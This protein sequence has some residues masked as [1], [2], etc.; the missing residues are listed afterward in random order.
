MDQQLFAEFTSSKAVIETDTGAVT[1]PYVRAGHGPALLLLHGFPQS[2]AMWHKVAPALAEHFTVIASDLR[3][4]GDASRPTAEGKNLYSKRAMAKDQLELMRQL[5]FQRFSILAHDR[6]ARVAHRLA[7]DHSDAVDRL[8]VLDIAP[9]LSMYEQTDV[10]FATVYWHWFFLIQR[11][12]LPETLISH[13][14]EFMLRSFMGGRHAGL[15]AFSPAAWAEYVRVAQDPAA[16]HAMCED[17]RAAATVDLEHDREDR[18]GGR[19]LKCPVSVIWGEFSGLARCLSP[20]E[21]WKE[22]A[23][24]VQGR[25]LPCGHYIAEEL[26]DILVKE[27][28]DFFH[29]KSE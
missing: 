17:Y 6:G 25:S 21:R 16:V 20:L 24:N 19:I 22:Y 1:I 23:D 27:A 14:P 12:P 2:H 28:L 18:A 29:A 8:M 15:G 5:G 11:S 9:T 4:Y 10:T 3:G 13:D 26:P 7:L